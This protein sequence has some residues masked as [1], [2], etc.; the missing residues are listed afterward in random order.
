MLI[1]IKKK[2]IEWDEKRKNK[3]LRDLDNIC[4]E[5]LALVNKK[6]ESCILDQ[7][8]RMQLQILEQRREESL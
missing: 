7:E 1:E 8:D 4:G 5:I 6:L 3:E 2:I